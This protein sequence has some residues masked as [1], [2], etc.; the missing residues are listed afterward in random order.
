M[1]TYRD[2]LVKVIADMSGENAEY[3][4]RDYFVDRELRFIDKE[5]AKYE[6]LKDQIWT[7]AI[8]QVEKAI[9]RSFTPNTVNV[10]DGVTICL[11]SD[12]HAGTVI[13]KTKTTITI[14]RDK[15][16]LDPNFKPEIVAGGYAGNCT[17]NEDQTYTYERDPE[18]MIET[19]RWSK[20][21]A[22]YQGGDDGSIKVIKGR[23]EFYD[24]NF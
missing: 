19:F 12:R 20:K 13:K 22:R 18:G 16:T 6:D 7:D 21:N 14:Q 23:Y 11:H 2:Q 15:A 4:I 8:E 5:I 10:G 9:D 17:N 24:Y 1:T 3:I